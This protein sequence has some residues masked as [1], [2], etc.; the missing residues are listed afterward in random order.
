M[1]REAPA[2]ISRSI[3]EKVYRLIDASSAA[4]VL[5]VQQL[6]GNKNFDESVVVE[7]ITEA[8]LLQPSLVPTLFSLL[9]LLPSP[10][11]ALTLKLLLWR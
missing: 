8:G 4:N 3:K 11:V 7:D 6:S 9:C 1:T 2:D 5:F 10:L